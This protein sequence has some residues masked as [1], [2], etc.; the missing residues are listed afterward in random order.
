MNWKN[1]LKA[2][3]DASDSTQGLH[4]T[5]F[6]MFLKRWLAEEHTEKFLEFF[7]LYEDLEQ[8]ERRDVKNSLQALISDT[9]TWGQPSMKYP[10]IEIIH[11]TDDMI[12]LTFD[13]DKHIKERDEWVKQTEEYKVHVKNT[14]GYTPWWVKKPPH[15]SVIQRAYNR[16]MSI[17]KKSKNRKTLTQALRPPSKKKKKKFGMGAKRHTGGMGKPRY[18]KGGYSI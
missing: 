7:W 16:L 12:A 5:K 13:D 3:W 18:S 8:F 9:G 10:G 14:R 4:V 6:Y 2:E 17:I 15:D 11:M 1:V